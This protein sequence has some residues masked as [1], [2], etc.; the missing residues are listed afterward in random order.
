[1]SSSLLERDTTFFLNNQPCTPA[2][3]AAG[4]YET[5]TAFYK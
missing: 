5:Y 1:M 4:T 2:E 3:I